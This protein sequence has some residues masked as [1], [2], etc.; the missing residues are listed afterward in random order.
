[1][2]EFFDMCEKGKPDNAPKDF[3][4]P[5]AL[6]KTDSTLKFLTDTAEGVETW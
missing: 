1:M 2:Y 3:V 5:L 6:I 4:K